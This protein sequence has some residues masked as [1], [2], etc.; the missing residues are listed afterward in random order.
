MTELNILVNLFLVV[1]LVVDML[2][3]ITIYNSYVLA[4]YNRRSTPRVMCLPAAK[5]PVSC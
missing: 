4:A 2:M 1:L 5:P 3:L